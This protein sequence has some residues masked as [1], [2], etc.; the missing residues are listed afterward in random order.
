MSVGS[1][2]REYRK[3]RGL[4]LAE[5]AQKIEMTPSYLSGVE[6]DLKKPSLPTLKKISQALNISLT[7]LMEK[8]D[9]S[10]TGEKLRLIR[11]GRGLSADE[12][13]EIS[14]IPVDIIRQFEANEKQP[15]IEQLE[16][17]SSAL[18]F[19]L[20][21]FSQRD[22]QSYALGIG[23]RLKELRLQHEMSITDL[24][25]KASVSPGLISQI[26]NNLTIPLLDTLEAIAA[27]LGTTADYF[28][29]ERRDMESFLMSMGPD[30]VEL[31]ADR[32]VQAVLG[33]IRDFNSLEMRHIL[34]YIQFYKSEK[35][36]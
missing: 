33:A 25:T 24:A 22:D 17:L 29:V 15:N 10:N 1:K 4:T 26:E 20:R 36:L 12:L 23:Q 5:L 11:E 16:N 35:G 31:L 28:L 3:E 9:N 21:F 19:T 30:V 34:K 27:C 32:N 8:A 13:A 14:E 7:Y 6:R 2:I 18:N